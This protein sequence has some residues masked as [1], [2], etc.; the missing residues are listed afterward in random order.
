MANIDLLLCLSSRW[1][2]IRLYYAN[3]PG[4]FAL[5]CRQAGSHRSRGRV[6]RPE[7]AGAVL[8]QMVEDAMLLG[9]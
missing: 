6:V 7:D 5:L 9:C 8:M 3:R 4:A 2:F 1:G